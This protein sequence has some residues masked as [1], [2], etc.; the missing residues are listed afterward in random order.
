MSRKKS[1]TGQELS[2]V[3][4]SVNLPFARAFFSAGT[5]PQFHAV[6]IEF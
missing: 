3:S 4:K 5:P 6:Y 2:A 1:V